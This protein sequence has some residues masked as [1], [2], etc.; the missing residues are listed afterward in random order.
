MGAD[1]QQ[2][3]REVVGDDY[4]NSMVKDK[5]IIVELWSS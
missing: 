3:V 5:R 1:V 4:Y 2:V